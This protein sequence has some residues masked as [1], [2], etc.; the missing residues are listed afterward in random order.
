MENG[1]TAVNETKKSS[2]K[3]VLTIVGNVIIW[4]FLIFAVLVTVLAFAAQQHNDGVPTIGGKAILNVATN[5]METPANPTDAQKKLMEGEFQGFNAGDIIIGQRLSNEEANNLK[6]GDIIT[7]TYDING[8]GMDEL[9]SHRIIRIEG[10]GNDKVYITH[11]DNNPETMEETVSWNMV[12]C[13]Y[14]GTRIPKLGNFLDF[15]QTRTGFLVCVVIPLVLFFIYELVNFIRKFM[16]LKNAGKKQITAA[17]EEL[18]RQQ[19]IEEYKKMMQQNASQTENAQE[20][21]AEAVNEQAQ[22]AKDAEP[23]VNAEAAANA[24]PAVNAE[25]AAEETKEEKTEE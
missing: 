8:D 22:E 20:S 10:E 19:A 4:L 7:Y 13:K 15:L 2:A 18:I 1:Q 23:A 14:N 12:I 9:N 16:K 17:D 24:E 11:G 21:A 6:V 3:K 5:S 25:A